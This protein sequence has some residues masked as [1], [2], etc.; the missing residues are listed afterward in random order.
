MN[1]RIGRSDAVDW[2]LDQATGRRF[3]GDARVQLTN[4][5]EGRWVME[6]RPEVAFRCGPY[7]LNSIAPLINP[8][9]ARAVQDFV[10]EVESPRSG[11]SLQ[12]VWRMAADH[13]IALQRAQR[14]QG[15]AIIV[16][17]VVHW[18]V[19]HFGAIVQRRGSRYLVEDPTFGNRTW[20]SAIA[21]DAEA[22]G[23]FL[24]PSG[25]LPLAGWT[26]V[27]SE[28]AASV[29]GR[30]YAGN[31]DPNP[32]FPDSPQTPP[33][34]CAGG[35]SGGDLA[36]ATYRV[37]LLNASLSVSDT[38]VG[39]EP[40]VG[41]SA[42][43]RVT[44]NQREANQ[45]STMDYTNFSPQW[46]STWVSYL[47][48]NTSSPGADVSLYHRGGG[49]E[50]FSDFD[51]MT[52]TYGLHYRTKGI[53]QMLTSN[54]Y[55]KV[56]PDGREEDYLHYIGTTGTERKV[57][58][59]HVRDPQGNEI[60]IVYDTTYPTRIDQ[61]VDPNGLATTFNY[62]YSG[63]PYL[64]TSVE[65]PYGRTAT[66][67]YSNV[68]GVLRL[69]EIEDVIG[70]TSTFTYDGEGEMKTLTTPYGTTSFKISPI[71]IAPGGSHNISR[72]IEITDPN[73]DRERI[74][75]ADGSA[76]T[77]LPYIA[78]GPLPDSSVNKSPYSNP[79]RNTFYWDK[80]QM[81]EG[82]G[83]YTKAHRYHWT[84]GSGTDLAT[85]VV[86]REKSPLEDTI[87]FN[88][89]GQ[90]T[91]DFGG[92]LASPSVVAR[93][94]KDED[95]NNATQTRGFEYNSQGNIT[96]R[97]DPLGR[98]TSFEYES[99]GID[100]KTVKQLVGESMG[101]PVW[102]TIVSYTYGS[103]PHQPA[104]ATDGAGQTTFYA[105]NS[106]GLV[107]TATNALG[108]TIV[109][110]YE[111]NPTA[112]GYRKLKAISGDAPGGAVYLTYDSYDRIS[113][114]TDSEGRTLSYTYDALDRL[115]TT[116]YPDSSYQQYDYV[117]HS[118]TGSR[119][120]SGRWTRHFYDSLMR[121]VATRDPLGR[122]S[123]FEWCRCGAMTKL[124]DGNGN[125]TKWSRDIEGRVTQKTHGDESSYSYEY[126]SSG[127]I[128]SIEDAIG[129]E[130]TYKYYLD[131]NVESIDFE[132]QDTPDVSF[133][134]DT[135]F[136]RASTRTDGSGVTSISYYDYDGSTSGAGLKHLEDGPLQD[137]TRKYTYDA[138]ARL[139]TFEV[140]DDAT[141]STASWQEEYTYDSRGRTVMVD[142]NL[143]TFTST[144]A[145]DSDR[146]LST[147]Y[148][149]GVR[150]E[151]EYFGPSGDFLLKQIKNLSS[152]LSVISK[153]DYTYNQDRTV[154]TWR[155]FQTSSGTTT[156]SFSYDDG[157]QLI[158]AVRTDSTATTV[159][160]ESYGYDHGA[161]R[162]WTTTASSA[163]AYIVNELNQIVAE[164]GFGATLV[165]GTVSEPTSVTVNGVAAVVRSASGSA[166]FSF[167]A[168]IDVPVG[169]SEIVI[170][171]SDGNSN[172]TTQRYEVA[173]TST[174][175]IYEYD[176]NGNLLFE[177]EPNN[178]VRRRYEWDQANRMTLAEIDGTKLE[179]RYDGLS[180]ATNLAVFDGETEESAQ[181]TIW[182]EN[183]RCETRSD[184][185]GNSKLF[186]SGLINGTDSVFLTMDH[187]GSARE[188][189]ASDGEELLAARDFSPW[190][191]VRILLESSSD[192]TAK[193]AGH[194]A[195]RNTMLYATRF[196][197]YDARFSRWL[198]RD[199]LGEG[200]SM[201]LYG[202]VDNDPIGFTD[203][204]G[205]AKGKRWPGDVTG[206]SKADEATCIARCTARGQFWSG[207]CY[208]QWKKQVK[209]VRAKVDLLTPIINCECDDPPDP[210]CGKNPAACALVLACI[211]AAGLASGPLLPVLAF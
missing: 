145:G 72:F 29:Y 99:N 26:A 197:P 24:I 211:L 134:Y 60:E 157:Q 123:Q 119:D 55:R 193:F 205:L 166:P 53:L 181:D 68:D 38:P 1:A 81:K 156:W 44:Y 25:T 121:R 40:A 48:D 117:N 97:V 175:T 192:A 153:F 125:A 173:R 137:D 202:Y 165:R 87:W 180:R 124:V 49:T 15:S 34:E 62:D 209:S 161:N 66:F 78:E 147:D 31:V 12:E 206:C 74:E 201:N 204:Y 169:T 4:A 22:S 83:D 130:T 139:K 79:Y 57:F 208:K 196:R 132:D 14:A 163:R 82:A 88:Y 67:S 5:T 91:P 108:N 50:V 136:D 111:T 9:A 176:Q 129:V 122:L 144:Y 32:T 73:G 98:T 36:M 42:R 76:I 13:G 174:T 138:L 61:L 160:A 17:S 113:S 23:F 158:D 187:L 199:P 52:D 207:R 185:L 186:S 159:E 151:F 118:L 164:R 105:Y 92:D 107:T 16:P 47:E 194:F 143:G 120:R 172:T 149:N 3:D 65:D 2:A 142:N 33:N 6:H 182:C 19:G 135:W 20:M 171:A 37:H 183:R 69:T 43:I 190:G 116:T 177:R 188:E 154:A 152:T 133:E 115:R 184:E 110:S 101:S 59:S 127:R 51:A 93:V 77:G 71:Y 210:A 96:K 109:Y 28:T 131:D 10:R 7:A 112:N 200:E 30:G 35:G 27:N 126:D 155:S 198:S 8:T 86:A 114:L 140:V 150:I 18:S 100:L 84:M 41:P 46:V 45:P 58:L 85:D 95:G 179:I 104:T 170:Q 106:L 56:Y 94:V 162:V 90:A 103:T 128:I 102:A 146:V 168:T 75:Y 141:T 21:I 11:F 80:L 167:E 54:T 70:I 89:P 189:V 191:E 39:Y 63:E 178:D 195:D 148:P 203:P 64:V